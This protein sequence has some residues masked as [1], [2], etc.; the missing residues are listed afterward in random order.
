MAD[1][2]AIPEETGI[3]T[4]GIERVSP[5]TRTHTR[6]LDNFTLWLSANLVISTIAFSWVAAGL[7][8]HADTLDPRY[9]TDTVAIR[10]TRLVHAGLIRLDP[11]TLVP[12]PYLA[13]SFAWTDDTTLRLELRDFHGNLKEPVGHVAIAVGGCGFI[14]TVRIGKERNPVRIDADGK[15]TDLWDLPTDPD[16]HDRFF[17]GR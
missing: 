1:I 9:A 11:T 13:R 14:G 8:L 3:E 12:A 2:V 4:H 5:E 16:V 6:I 17:D 15:I 10:A 7:A